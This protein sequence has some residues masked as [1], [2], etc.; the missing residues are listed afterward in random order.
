MYD[1]SPEDVRELL[2]YDPTTGLFTWRKRTR[3]WFTTERAMKGFNT[4]FAGK[5]ALTAND[6]NGYRHG[7]IM[8]RNYKAHRVAWAHY[9]GKWP[10]GQIDHIEGPIK[11][12]GVSNLRDVSHQV[13]AKN[14]KR[15]SANTTGVTGVTFHKASGKFHAYINVGGKR[16]SLGYFDSLEGAA[17]ARKIADVQHGFHPNHG[18]ISATKGAGK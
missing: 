11:G 5:P 14:Q 15:S 18:R 3:K 2:D 17:D 13:N 8:M 1:L 4:Q 16:K 10:T 6:G 9:H 12:D 7:Q